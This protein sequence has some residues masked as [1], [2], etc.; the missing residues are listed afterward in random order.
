MTIERIAELAGVSRST[1]SRVIN[2]SPDVREETR[3]RVM[4][5]IEE[6]G[7]YPNA[8]ARSLASRKSRTI[9]VVD[10]SSV[11][12]RFGDLF[13]PL[14]LLRG[15]AKACQNSN[16][17]VM[18]SNVDPN[19]PETYL[20]LVNSGEVAGFILGTGRVG[21]DMMEHLYLRNVPFILIGTHPPRPDICCVTSDNVT[22][23]FMA[24]RYLAGKGYKRIAMLTGS[25]GMGTAMDRLEGFKQGMASMGL[26]LPPEYVIW[27]RQG[28]SDA[29]DA[30]D[31]FRALPERP[32]AIFCWSD[33][34]AIRTLDWAEQHGVRVPQD[35]A[36]M[37]FDGVPFAAMTNPPLTTI[38]QQAIDIGMRAVETLVKHLNTGEPMASS[39]LPVRLIERASC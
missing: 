38:E 2:N 33:P 1:V 22:G 29:Y 12:A 10:P 7:Y 17:N 3:V 27:T 6:Q 39:T 26:E 31:R 18:L 21:V 4:R 28:N 15:I 32:D 30:M 34:P 8:A 37:G 36:V 16:Y 19:R 35:L 13:F 24:A 14:M 11:D 20:S 9:A 23:G 5:V 25:K